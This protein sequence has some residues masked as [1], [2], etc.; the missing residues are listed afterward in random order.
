MKRSTRIHA[1]DWLLH[2]QMVVNASLDILKLFVCL[3][4]CLF[5]VASS[6]VFSSFDWLLGIVNE[7]VFNNSSIVVHCSDG[8]D[9][10]SMYSHLYSFFYFRFLSISLVYSS[11]LF[12]FLLLFFDIIYLF[13]LLLA[14]LCTLAELIMDPYFRTIEGFEVL[15]E[16]DWLSFGTHLLLTFLFT[17]LLLFYSSFLF[18]T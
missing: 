3:F 1:S 6:F 17:F 16:K 11:P 4:V 18:R 15:I 5:V 8:W 7:M 2:L 14:Q 13:T 9:R 10:T 12:Y